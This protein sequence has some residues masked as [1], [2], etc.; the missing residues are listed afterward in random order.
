MFGKKVGE[1][2]NFGK[3]D[4]VMSEDRVSIAQIRRYEDVIQNKIK[5]GRND[6]L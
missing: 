2:K 3:E 6:A 5:V 4:L 1:R